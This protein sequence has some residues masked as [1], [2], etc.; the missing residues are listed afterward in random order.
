MLR[1][2]GVKLILAVGVTTIL[3]IGVYSFVNI[4]S[5][6]ATL[7]EEVERHAGQLSE[8][9][10]NSTRYSMMLNQREHI[11]KIINDIG[12]DPEIR[13][14]RI[15]NKEGEIIYSSREENIGKM[16][17][18][19]A[20]SC[21]ACHA[22]DKPLERLSVPE[23]TRIFKID[24][25][26]PRVLGMINPIYTEQGCWQAQ[27]HAHSKDQSVLGVLDIAISLNDVDAQITRSQ[28]ETGTF[29]V[30]AVLVISLTIAF[31]VR[32]FVDVPVGGLVKAT[33]EIGTGNLDYRITPRTNDD[34]GTLARSFNTMTQKLSEARLQ[35][36]QSDKMASLGRLAAG[37]AH[38]INNPLTGVLTYSSFLLKRCRDNP[39][40]EEDL[41]VIVREATRSR[42]IVKNLLDFA[43]QS[44]PNKRLHDVNQIIKRSAE[45]V[46]NQLSLKKINLQ[47][48][49]AA[50]L[51]PALVDSNQMQQVMV[52]LLVNAADAIETGEGSIV[53]SSSSLR[54][55]PIGMV[56][57]RKAT[58]P[59]G[60]DLVDPEFRIGGIPAVR[61]KARANGAEGLVMLD[62]VYRRAHH[63]YTFALSDDRMAQF[64]CPDCG[65]SL[66]QA[67]RPCPRCGAATFVLEIPGQGPFVGCSR[68]GC[69]WQGWEWMDARGQRAY[70]E[71]KVT[72]SGGGIPKEHLN[73]IFEPFFTTKGQRGTGLGLAVIWGIV[74]NHNGSIEVES[75]VGKGTTFCIR[76]PQNHE[77]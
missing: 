53:V 34:L 17:D 9:I 7:L 4:R 11:H 51:P 68:K 28:I 5:Q 15:L 41:K 56:H 32:R 62:P 67:D 26:S 10:K 1:K 77:G 72:D 58:C 13:E 29:A 70:F 65:I 31:F 71:I 2:I 12:N 60:H 6:Q 8:T 73:R 39:A 40:V 50:S 45:V 22:A 44:I 42:E 57:V 16:V 14:V 69:D 52:N 74:D 76:I 63:H 18:K 75:E 61:V 25:N 23:R 55:S 33:Q 66:M 38:E 3:T 37:V 19:R 36:F 35:V 27:C 30:I 21:Y 43:R 48:N 64:M 24:P 47:L 54:L 49:L 59:K 20:E 46:E